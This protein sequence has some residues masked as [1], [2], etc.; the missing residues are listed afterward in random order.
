M[1]FYKLHCKNIIFVSLFKNEPSSF[2]SEIKTLELGL[3]LAR[4]QKN[5][6]K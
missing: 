6:K 5:I 2:L 1:H 3:F 4:Y